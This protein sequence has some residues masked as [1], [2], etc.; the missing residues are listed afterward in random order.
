MQNTKGIEISQDSIY[1][2]E[3]RVGAAVG[4]KFSDKGNVYA[5]THVVKE[6]VGDVDTEYTKDGVYASTAEDFG[7]T[8]FE[9][10]IGANYRFVEN[11]NV[12]ADIER[13]GDSTVETKWQ[14]NLGFRYEF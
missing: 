7:D 14:G 10:G 2:A 13:T 1:T 11:M 8:W 9:F 5:R 3:G 12:Y 6:F 4:Y